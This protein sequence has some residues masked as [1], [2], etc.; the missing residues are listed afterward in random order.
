MDDETKN[1]IAVGWA[2]FL[3]IFIFGVAAFLWLMMP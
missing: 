2:I 3:I 1:K